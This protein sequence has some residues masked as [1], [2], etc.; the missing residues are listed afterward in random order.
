LHTQRMEKGYKKE[1]NEA[2]GM[3]KQYIC[4]H[5]SLV[6]IKTAWA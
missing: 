5:V 6:R 1:K 4:R 2:G 3:G